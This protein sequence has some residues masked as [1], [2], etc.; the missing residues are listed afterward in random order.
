MQGSFEGSRATFMKNTGKGRVSAHYLISKTG[1]LLQMVK[2]EMAAWHVCNANPFC[3]GI[4]HEDA[5]F[6]RLGGGKVQLTRTCMNDPNWA[7]PIELQTSAKLT[8]SLIKKYN[9]P[10]D[11]LEE[12]VIGH[13]SPILKK[14]G[15][16]HPCPGPYFPWTK[17][18]ELVRQE[19]ISGQQ[20]QEPQASNP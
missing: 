18:Y 14:Y 5:F 6:T 8:A 10:Q 4:E 20:G 17:Y 2:D 15:N 3:I 11:K 9:L 19:L 1:Q 13:N 16:N 12:V 7:T